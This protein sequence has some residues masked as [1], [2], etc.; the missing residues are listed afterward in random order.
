MNM[1]V[2]YKLLIVIL[3]KYKDFFV[4]S[5]FINI[6]IKII[7]TTQNMWLVCKKASPMTL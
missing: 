4:S 2:Y 6:M 5:K 7:W 1:F 3:S